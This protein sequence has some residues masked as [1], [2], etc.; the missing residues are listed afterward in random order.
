MSCVFAWGGG[1]VG[2]GETLL[3]GSFGGC[4]GVAGTVGAGLDDILA[5]E[6]TGVETVAL[7]KR[8]LEGQ[9]GVDVDC[10]CHFF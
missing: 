7:T 1:T 5:V 3:V 2:L 10:V 4:L 8:A 9:D 6:N